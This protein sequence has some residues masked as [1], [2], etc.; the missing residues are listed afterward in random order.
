MSYLLIFGVR[1]D[2]IFACIFYNDGSMNRFRVAITP[3][4]S[5]VD[6]RCGCVSYL[7]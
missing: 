2:K 7:E 4:R 1:N 5:L 3:N 6:N